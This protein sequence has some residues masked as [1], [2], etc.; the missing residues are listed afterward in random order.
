[1]KFIPVIYGLQLVNI[2]L[3]MILV[4]FHWRWFVFRE[5]CKKDITTTI[6]NSV[7]CHAFSPIYFAS[8]EFFEKTIFTSTHLAVFLDICLVLT[9]INSQFRTYSL[10][11]NAANEYL[12][13]LTISFFHIISTHHYQ[14]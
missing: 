10:Q 14:S 13:R 2:T 9:N 3:E 11:N 8:P 4:Y 1:M 7:T 12:G 5:N 6:L